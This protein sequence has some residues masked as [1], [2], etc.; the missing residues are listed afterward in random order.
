VK[1]QIRA[2]CEGDAPTLLR[3]HDAIV[4]GLSG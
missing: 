1:W 3:D 4:I 2:W